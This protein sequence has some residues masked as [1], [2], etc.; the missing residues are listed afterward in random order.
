MK[1]LADENID[2]PIVEKLR[3]K[4]F[5]ISAIEEES[6]GADDPELS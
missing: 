4:G 1:L 6:K 2:Q 3:S 5:N